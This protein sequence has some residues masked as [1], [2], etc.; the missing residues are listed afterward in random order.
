M[1]G[2]KRYHSLKR[3]GHN[4]NEI[5]IIGWTRSYKN[6]ATTD[7]NLTKMTFP[8][9]CCWIIQHRKYAHGFALF[10]FSDIKDT[11]F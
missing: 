9:L 6:G 2:N 1:G 7:E 3:K 5:F 8:S 11:I 10:E 4:L